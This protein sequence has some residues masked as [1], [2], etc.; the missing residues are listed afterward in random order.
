[1]P[2]REYQARDPQKGCARCQEP[3]ER[4]E[5]GATPPLEKCPDCGAPLKR[6][7]SAPAIG[8]S[9]SSFDQRAAQA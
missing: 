9:K 8:D 3:F 4:L 1:M 6:L 2:L 7:I 5:Q